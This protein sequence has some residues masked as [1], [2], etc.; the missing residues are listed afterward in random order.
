VQQNFRREN[1]KGLLFTMGW[2]GQHWFFAF[3]LAPHR[4]GSFCNE[5]TLTEGE[6]PLATGF[7]N[8]QSTIEVAYLILQ[9]APKRGVFFETC[10]AKVQNLDIYFLKNV[11]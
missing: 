10:I 9:L 3:L 1:N 4:R 8:L 11:S 7:Y 6:D 2:S 5:V